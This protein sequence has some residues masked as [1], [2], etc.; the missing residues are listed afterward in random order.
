MPVVERDLQGW[1]VSSSTKTGSITSFSLTSSSDAIFQGYTYTLT[2]PLPSVYRVV[3]TGPYRPRPPQDNIVL[4]YKPLSFELVSLDTEKST[5]VFSFPESNEIKREIH[6]TW[7]DSI[8]LSVYEESN[9]EKIRLLGDLPSRSYALTEH[10]I[11]RH[12][13]IEG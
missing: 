1:E 10:G 7:R 8:I 12:W 6:L 13:W 5:A 9:G 2:F 4:K 3:L 11:I